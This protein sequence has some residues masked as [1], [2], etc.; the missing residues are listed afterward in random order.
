MATLGKILSRTTE[1]FRPERKVSSK[2]M[3]LVLAPLTAHRKGK[4]IF[5]DG[6]AV[7]NYP[8]RRMRGYRSP[9][10]MISIWIH[11]AMN[12]WLTVYGRYFI[13]LTA[14]FSIVGVTTILMPAYI[15]SVGLVSLFLVDIVYGWYY[16]PKLAIKRELPVLGT[17]GA[18]LPVAYRVRN[19]GRRSCW[20]LFVDVLPGMDQE[21]VQGVPWIRDLGPDAEVTLETTLRIHRRGR[22][23]IP[24]CLVSSAFPFGLWRWGSRA[25]PNAPV[26]IFPQYEPLAALDLPPGGRS[27]RG[28]AVIA[29]TANESVEFMG[30]R[31]YQYGDNPRLIHALSWARLQQPVVKEFREEYM[32]RTAIVVDV[33]CSKRGYYAR[34]I[35]RDNP[36]LEALASLA[37]AVADNLCRR[38]H[39]VDFFLAGSL[40]DD[41]PPMVPGTR[42]AGQLEEILKVVAAIEESA[43]EEFQGLPQEQLQRMEDVRSA[44]V[45]LPR[46]DGQRKAFLEDLAARGVALKVIVIGGDRPA[47]EDSD[48]P[49]IHLTV[50]DVLAGE[51]K[52]L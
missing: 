48:I 9:N 19:R 16:R 12:I 24:V 14:A 42:G 29:S 41:V 34:L 43:D 38:N 11:A 23:D 47:A 10:V 32:T 31:E 51:V 21:W 52:Q 8:G 22:H 15:L 18:D 44:V 33:L 39:L 46:L 37:A 50:D 40:P 25:A 1:F 2:W 7:Y 3:W 13:L 26:Y 6:P 45:I 27:H 28:H 17:V 5:Y 4:R 20:S 35:K 49:I 36:Q 30:L